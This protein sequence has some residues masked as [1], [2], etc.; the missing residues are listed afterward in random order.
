MDNN[1]IARLIEREIN[2]RD[3]DEQFCGA[4]GFALPVIREKKNG[5]AINGTERLGGCSGKGSGRNQTGNPF[6]TSKYADLASVQSACMPHLTKNGLSVVQTIKHEAN[7]TMLVTIL[8]HSSGQ[9]MKSVAPVKPTKN[10]PQ[11]LGSA[12]TYMR[13]YSLASMVGVAQEDD[14]GNTA[15][16]TKQKESFS[17]GYDDGQNKEAYEQNLKRINGFSNLEDLNAYWKEHGNRL[18]KLPKNYYEDLVQAASI[19]KTEIANKQNGA[20]H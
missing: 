9:W 13:R 15:S 16:N 6:C 3:F 8:L 20:Q 1:Q 19:V 12:L 11:G 14:D 18:K 10:D 7:E 5:N 2:N 4:N 17:M